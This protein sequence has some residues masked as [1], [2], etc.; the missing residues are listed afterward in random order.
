MQSFE[1]LY[2]KLNLKSISIIKMDVEGSELE[3][4]KGLKKVLSEERP[5]ILCEIL[6][7][8]SKNDTF[9]KPRQEEIEK[10]IKIL[11]YKICRIEKEKNGKLKGLVNLNQFGI[12]SNLSL[13]DYLFVPYEIFEDVSKQLNLK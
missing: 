6:P 9:R 11:N 1:Y 12:H 2:K 7:V 8:S 5:F 4:F 3:V 13:S 10:I